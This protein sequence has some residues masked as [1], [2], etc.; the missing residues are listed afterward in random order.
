MLSA[1]ATRIEAETL[2]LRALTYVVGDSEL[3]PRLLDMTGLDVAT[4]RNRA[5]DPALLAATLAFLEGHEPS[6]LACASALQAD[7]QSLI[8]ALAVLEPRRLR[9]ATA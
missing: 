7:P 4:L 3:G 5:S 9:K 6:L 1:R 8:A 2:A